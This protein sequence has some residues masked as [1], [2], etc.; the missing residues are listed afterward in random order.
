MDG[1][2]DVRIT[3]IGGLADFLQAVRLEQ[4][5]CYSCRIQVT[6]RR[7]TDGQG[8]VTFTQI[9]FTIDAPGSGWPPDAWPGFRNKSPESVL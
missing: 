3:G 2:E 6:F 9:A 7:L 1:H 4:F 8:Y 5:C